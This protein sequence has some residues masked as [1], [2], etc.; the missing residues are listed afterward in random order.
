MRESM[1]KHN[2][3]KLILT[4]DSHQ[5][6]SFQA[7]EKQFNLSHIEQLEPSVEQRFYGTGRM[8]HII[9]KHYYKGKK[10][11]KVL[12]QIIRECCAI[13]Q[14]F[15]NDEVIN[16]SEYFEPQ[17]RK[18]LLGVSIEDDTR[19][20]LRTKLIEYAAFY[21][22]DNWEPIGFEVGFS[23]KLY[24]DGTVIFIYEGRIDMPI[25]LGEQRVIVDHKTQAF[26]YELNERANSFIGYCWVYGAK[27]AI[28]NYIGLQVTKD[29]K[30][31][32]RRTI[33]SFTPSQIEKWREDTIEWYF[34]ILRAKIQNRWLEN[35]NSCRLPGRSAKGIP[36]QFIS[37]CSQIYPD[38]IKSII[39]RD[40]KRREKPWKSW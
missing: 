18:D 15:G 16:Q 10:E 6:S 7:C 35:R 29:P 5:L 24:E 13:I 34:R 32:F 26:S 17:D 27:T 31:C 22:N 38:V 21:Q 11:K 30:E 23:Q 4:L 8:F 33:L 25:L 2:E 14:T 40:Y 1:K 39:E 9:L 3:E 12:N 20:L 28:I 36:C 37:I 19:D